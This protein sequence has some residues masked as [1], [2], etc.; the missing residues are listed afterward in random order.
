MSAYRGASSPST[1][2]PQCTHRKPPPTWGRP[3]AAQPHEPRRS[4]AGSESSPVPPTPPQLGA[5]RARPLALEGYTPIASRSPVSDAAAGIRAWYPVR[6]CRTEPHTPALLAM[7]W[8]LSAGSGRTWASPSGRGSTPGA[9]SCCRSRPLSVGGSIIRSGDAERGV[10]GGGAGMD[11]LCHAVTDGPEGSDAVVLSVDRAAALLAKARHGRGFWCSSAADGCGAPLFVVAGPVRRPH[12]RHPSGSACAYARDARRAEAAYTHLAIQHALVR[13]LTTQGFTSRME[14]VLVDG[15]RADVHVVVGDGAQTIEVQLSA[16]PEDEWRRRDELYR[17]QVSCTTWLYGPDAEARAIDEVVQRHTALDVAAE[18]EEAGRWR[19]DIGTRDVD[20]VAWDALADC[21]LT[22]DGIWTPHLDAA[23]ARTVAWR[24]ELDAARRREE[25]A[26]TEREQTRQVAYERRQRALPESTNRP[27]SAPPAAP[28]GPVRR[29]RRYRLDPRRP[30]SPASRSGDMV[31]GLRVGL[32][33]L[34]PHRAA[35]AGPATRLHRPPRRRRRTHP[36]TRV[37]RR[38]RPRPPRRHSPPRRQAHRHRCTRRLPSPMASRRLRAGASQST[39]STIQS[40]DKPKR[41]HRSNEDEWRGE[42]RP[43]AR[44]VRCMRS[45]SRLTMRSSIHAREA[46]SA[47][48]EEAL[49][50]ALPEGQ[51]GHRDAF[52]RAVEHGREVERGGQLQGYEPV[53]VDP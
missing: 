5:R 42:V 12:F 16:L 48:S 51:S 14:H 47:A 45:S 15:G 40:L 31:P 44:P 29:A 20:T 17:S 24:D 43:G 11:H 34:T 35:G 28:A 8:T 33:Q 46:S 4:N 49:K 3:D 6:N 22:P 53:A 30:A 13:W 37:P 10:A 9:S 7:P 23:R 38:P 52:V 18:V 50:N 39:P 26:V 2:P 1:A 19:V 27:E 36:T 32:A 41:A 25:E 21:K